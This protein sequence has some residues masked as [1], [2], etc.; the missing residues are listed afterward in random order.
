M[1]KKKFSVYSMTVKGKI[2]TLVTVLLLFMVVVAGVGLF[3]SISINKSRSDRY[4]NYAMG[5][6]YLSEAFTNFCNIKVRARNAIFVYYND[7][8]N[9]DDQKTKIENYKTAVEDNF[10]KFEERLDVFGSDV[11][12]KFEEVEVSIDEW[13]VST[14]EDIELAESGQQEAAIQDLMDEGRVIADRAEA[15]LSELI[16]LLEAESAENNELV[17]TELTSRML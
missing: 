5:E 12:T 4:N 15:E 17:E 11:R 2:I 14:D 3:S 13:Y 9:L 16:E 6:Y 1:K 7:P 8:T 10:S